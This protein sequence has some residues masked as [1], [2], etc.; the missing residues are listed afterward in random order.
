MYAQPIKKET[1]EE[2]IA[3]LAAMGFDDKA[4]K[5]VGP[6]PLCSSAPL[7][8]CSSAL[9]RLCASAPLVLFSA[10]HFCLVMPLLDAVL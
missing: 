6:L 4:C 5:A 9:L 7:L 1:Q 8:L 3:K 2:K 10:P